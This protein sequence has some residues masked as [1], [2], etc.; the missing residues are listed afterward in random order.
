MV[1]APSAV[2]DTLGETSKKGISD[3]DI[4]QQ[5]AALKDL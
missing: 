3:A 4:E 1:N 5:L 2:R